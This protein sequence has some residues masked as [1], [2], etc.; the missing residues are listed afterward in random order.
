MR[1]TTITRYLRQAAQLLVISSLLMTGIA[2]ARDYQIEVVLFENVDGRDLT[3]GGLYFPK[4]GR[5]LRLGTEDAVAAGFI[6]LE[7]NLSLAENAKSIAASRRYR[8]IRHL[9]WR[10]PGLAVDDAIPVRISLGE[11]IP[12][13]LPGSISEYQDFI[14]ASADTSPERERKINTSTVNGSIKVHLGRFLHMDAQLVFTDIETQ[15]SFRL[16]Q[17]R[18]MRSRELHYIDNPRFGI[19]TRILPIE[20]P[21]G[22]VPEAESTDNDEPIESAPE[23]IDENNREP[24]PEE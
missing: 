8:L 11:T 6:P 18:K 12:L 21:E 14:P 9:S 16:S 5:S 3:A 15:Q 24:G 22:S 2:H 17:S 10:Q 23:F 7:Q 4:L 13:Y 20:D 19:L 1:I